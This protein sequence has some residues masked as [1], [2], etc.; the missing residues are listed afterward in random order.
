MA[1]IL[2]EKGKLDVAAQKYVIA[3]GESEPD[4]EN[5]GYFYGLGTIYE[6]DGKL[7]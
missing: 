2:R 3:I 6:S 4:E 5:I 7:Q 1:D